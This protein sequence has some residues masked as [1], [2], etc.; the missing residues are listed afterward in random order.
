ME[1]AGEN[2]WSYNTNTNLTEYG[3]YRGIEVISTGVYG[4]A[5]AS[6]QIGSGAVTVHKRS[7]DN[8]NGWSRVLNFPVN[9]PDAVPTIAAD[10]TGVYV[11]IMQRDLLAGGA[12]TIITKLNPVDGS[13]ISMRDY[14]QS[15]QSNTSA[16]KVDSTGIY[17]F[18]S[19]Y[20]GGSP[21]MGFGQQGCLNVNNLNG[22]YWVVEKWD[23]NLASANPIWEYT[24]QQSSGTFGDYFFYSF[25]M[26]SDSLFLGGSHMELFCTT[27]A[28]RA[29]L[30]SVDKTTGQRNWLQIDPAGSGVVNAIAV[31]DSSLYTVGSPNPYFGASG[32]VKRNINNGSILW[33]RAY[34]NYISALLLEND[35]S[36][37]YAQSIYP[38]TRIE[39][40]STADGS[41]VGPT[42][43]LTDV[44]GIYDPSAGVY[45]DDTVT[46]DS[47]KIDNTGSI[48]IG[49]IGGM[50]ASTNM[51]NLAGAYT[52]IKKYNPFETSNQPPT[53]PVVTGPTNGTINTNYTFFVNSTD[54]D[55]GDTIRYGFDWNNDAVVDIWAP[56]SSYVPS[57]QVQSATTSWSTA[58]AQTF[59]VLAEDN[60]GAR[61]GWSNYT[62]NI[63]VTP[64]L[65][66]CDNNVTLNV[67]DSVNITARFWPNL[68]YTPTC[69]TPGYTDVTNSAVW[70]SS[71]STFASVTNSGTRGLVTA[72]S[73]GSATIS[74][75]YN[76]VIATTAVNVQA[77]GVVPI[78]SLSVTSKE[79]YVRFNTATDVT[80]KITSNLNLDC[81]V[82]GL[83]GAPV[84]ISY[85]ALDSEVTYGPLP[86]INLQSEQAVYVECRNPSDSTILATSREYIEVIPAFQ[87]I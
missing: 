65:I 56:T 27:I 14:P 24:S 63:S 3:G 35:T 41:K 5:I 81:T 20:V 46:S 49:G 44:Y 19:R 36:L 2:V 16:I 57:G 59:R 21:G 78:I 58:G 7:L 85:T 71:D 26:N 45:N 28:Y 67:G 40:I 15:L 75:T 39:K 17:V 76:S 60:L 82:Y 87:E 32:I 1:A 72:N 74:A 50:S 66:N 64:R 80:I 61:S 25:E 18:K 22:A 9:F 31:N 70:S 73:A 51:Y 52:S 86:T 68:A 10:E 37:I 79:D 4:V 43:I 34:S 84:N 8:T 11:A 42:T 69:L 47:V 53:S 12:F 54:P 29:R 30:E 6:W 38:G 23:K 83:G 55:A 62:N 13:I 48:Y 77:L 33:S